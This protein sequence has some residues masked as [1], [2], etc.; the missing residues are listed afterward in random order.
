MRADHHANPTARAKSL[1]DAERLFFPLGQQCWAFKLFDA[2]AAAFAF[3]GDPNLLPSPGIRMVSVHQTRAFGNDHS[4]ST[5]F[6]LSMFFCL[7]EQSN[8]GL[9]VVGILLG[10]EANPASA[11]EVGNGKLGARTPSSVFPD[12]G[13]G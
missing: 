8:Q 10:H 2:K 5:L 7:L 6:G 13:V 4:H 12:A 1:I 9:D 11:N 3:F